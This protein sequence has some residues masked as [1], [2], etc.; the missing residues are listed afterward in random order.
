MHGSACAAAVHCDESESA[1]IRTGD[2]Q[3]VGIDV[4]ESEGIAL[5]AVVGYVEDEAGS[6]RVGGEGVPGVII[7]LVSRARLGGL[8]P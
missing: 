6:H 2:T 1:R 3:G 5:L 7:A 4:D 8:D